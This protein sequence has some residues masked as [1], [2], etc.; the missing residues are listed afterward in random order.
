LI[1]GGAATG[2]GAGFTGPDAGCDAWAGVLDPHPI[3]A[4]DLQLPRDVG[5]IASSL[6]CSEKL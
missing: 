1:T 5:K 4:T 3:S 6:E 2:F